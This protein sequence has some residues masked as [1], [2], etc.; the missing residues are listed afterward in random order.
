MK[1]QDRAEATRRHILDVAAETFGWIGYARTNLH[2]IV[3]RADVTKGALYYHFESKESL[4]GEL[5]AERDRR[6]TDTARLIESLSLPAFETV[7]QLSMSTAALTCSDAYVR[8]GD[9]LLLEIAD[10]QGNAANS[11]SLSSERLT[12]LLEQSVEQG[13][14]VAADPATLCR[15]MLSHAVGTRIVAQATA[16]ACD[17]LTSIEQLWLLLIRSVVTVAMQEY[18]NQV[19]V[20]VA[21]AHRAKLGL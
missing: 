16:D 13:D 1:R 19:V 15:V 7:I 21:S 3:T 9:R 18:F 12:V 4:A 10:L 17:V 8:A 5:I 2:D 11:I 14:V 20:R 6:V